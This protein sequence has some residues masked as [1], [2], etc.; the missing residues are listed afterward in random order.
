MPAGGVVPPED[1]LFLIGRN[2][3][4]PVEGCPFHC[5]VF[6]PDTGFEVVEHGH[7]LHIILLG[8]KNNERLAGSS[9]RVSLYAPFPGNGE[10]IADVLAE[11]FLVDDRK[12]FQIIDSF[13]GFDIDSVIELPVESAVPDS[14]GKEIP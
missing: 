12:A 7:A 13:N 11:H 9:S 1:L 8:E 3:V 4:L 5:P 10:N 14:I 2:D 6:E